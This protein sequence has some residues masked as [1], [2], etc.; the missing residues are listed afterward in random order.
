MLSLGISASTEKAILAANYEFKS[1]VTYF[2]Q[3]QIKN[4]EGKVVA[5]PI[6]G[7]GSGD[8]VNLINVDGFLELPKEKVEFQA[9]E[10]YPIIQFR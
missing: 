1:P 7:G 2:L 8:F 6:A 4:E 9:G 3:V 10:A 5:Y